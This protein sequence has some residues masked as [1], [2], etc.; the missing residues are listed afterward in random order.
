ME[1][2]KVT[3]NQEEARL[4]ET[5]L[6]R[7]QRRQKLIEHL[8]AYGSGL[9][10]HDR[11]ISEESKWSGRSGGYAGIGASPGTTSVKCR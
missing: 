11:S 5:R 9:A 8:N 10:Y 7:K 6:N 3:A 1:G 2:V 4:E